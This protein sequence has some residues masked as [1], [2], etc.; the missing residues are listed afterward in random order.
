[1]PEFDWTAGVDATTYGH[2]PFHPAIRNGRIVWYWPNITFPK[3]D[4]AHEW[5]KLALAEALQTTIQNVARWNV[6]KA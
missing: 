4:E 1:M 3:E 2:G 6:Y 5:A